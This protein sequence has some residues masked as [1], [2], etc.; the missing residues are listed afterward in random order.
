MRCAIAIRSKQSRRIKHGALLD[1]EIL[2]EVYGEL[3]GGRQRSLGLGA[4][5]VELRREANREARQRPVPLPE[6]LTA[7]ERAA[8]AAFVATLGPGAIWLSYAA[9]SAPAKAAAG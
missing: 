1:A 8:H 9:D 3:L 4:R 2:V 5:V 7:A 6:R